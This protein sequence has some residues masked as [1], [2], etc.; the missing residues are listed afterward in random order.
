MEHLCAQRRQLQHFVIGDSVQLTRIRHDTRVSG[1]NAVH[2]RIDLAQ[3]R[4]QHRR[5]RNRSR[6]RTAAAEGS[7]VAHLVD[8]L[9]A[10]HDADLSI[11]QL[12]AQALCRHALDPRIRIV[13]VGFQADLPAGQRNHGKAELLDRHGEQ[14]HGNH[15]TGVQQDVHL[16]LGRMIVQLRGLCDQVIRRVA[17][18]GYDDHYLVACLRR[19][20]H[21]VRDILQAL[22]VC[23]RSA[24]ELLHNK[25]HICYV[26]SLYRLPQ[27]RSRFKCV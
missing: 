20:G 1:I 12:S 24:A 19:L 8:A 22:G 27:A 17:L 14:R 5:N 16:A 2:I 11:I 23:N 15:L 3:V 18:R 13:A 26:S 7:H 21:D 25:T 9:K 6:I 4:A 10:C